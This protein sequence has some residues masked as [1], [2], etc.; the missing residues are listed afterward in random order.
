MFIDDDDAF[1]AMMKGSWKLTDKEPAPPSYTSNYG[2][3]KVVFSNKQ[4]HGDILGWQQE[5]S[6][7]E[8]DT[9]HKRKPG[10]VHKDFERSN[11]FL[12]E[13]DRPNM[14]SHK[15]ISSVDLSWEDPPKPPKGRSIGGPVGS[16]SSAAAPPVPYQGFHPDPNLSVTPASSV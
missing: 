1:E 7:L 13:Y 8:N 10:K 4:H 3:G 16:S 5:P 11:E 6:H 12:S 2:F 14:I 15:N 9:P